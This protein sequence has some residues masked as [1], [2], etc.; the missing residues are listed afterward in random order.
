MKATHCIIEFHRNS[1]CPKNLYMLV[2]HDILP[3]LNCILY[4]SNKIMTSD[5]MEEFD[6]YI[7]NRNQA[8]SCLSVFAGVEIYS[9]STRNI[10]SEWILTGFHILKWQGWKTSCWWQHLK[11]PTGSLNK[12]SPLTGQPY[13]VVH[14]SHVSSSMK[15]L[16]YLISNVYF[17][18]IYQVEICLSWIYLTL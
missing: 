8:V 1:K 17:N 10:Q 7:N 11:P 9:L 4:D 2:G 3:T 18:N 5:F 15:H 6:C 16:D 13:H 12:F 14:P